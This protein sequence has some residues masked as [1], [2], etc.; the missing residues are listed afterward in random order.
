MLKN[1]KIYSFF[2]FK[3]FALRNSFVNDVFIL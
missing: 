1:V 2:D 3:K